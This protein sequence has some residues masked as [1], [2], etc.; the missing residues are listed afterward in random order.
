MSLHLVTSITASILNTE[1]IEFCTKDT[2]KVRSYAGHVHIDSTEY[3]TPRTTACRERPTPP[4]GPKRPSP[5]RVTAAPSPVTSSCARGRSGSGPRARGSGRERAAPAQDHRTGRRLGPV[6][7]SAGATPDV[8][9]RVEERQRLGDIV[10]V[11]A[12]R[13]DGRRGAVRVGDHV[14]FRAR[15]CTVDRA[16]TC[17]GPPRRV[18]ASCRLL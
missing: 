7:R 18:M 9:D 11:A 12:G 4:A 14:V 5:R 6:A 10:S 15:S 17:L 13:R 8:R 1:N 3:P 2:K 16:R